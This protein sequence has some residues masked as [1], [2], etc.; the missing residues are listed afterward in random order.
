MTTQNITTKTEKTL[1]WIQCDLKSVDNT[2]SDTWNY[3][4]LEEAQKDLLYVRNLYPKATYRIVKREEV[5]E[6]YSM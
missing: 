2:W 6:V 3:D 1:Y 5:E 4:S